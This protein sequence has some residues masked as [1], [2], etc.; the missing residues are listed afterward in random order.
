MGSTVFE[1]L[2]S[3]LGDSNPDTRGAA[4][5]AL[6]KASE[7]G[8]P[9]AVRLV[10]PMLADVYPSVR[11]YALAALGLLSSS[12]YRQVIKAIT[13]RLEDSD[14]SVRRL[15]AEVL[16]NFKEACPNSKSGSFISRVPR[17]P[18]WLSR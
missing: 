6:S 17:T 15:A 9:S 12:D 3:R 1:I 8:N 13:S 18:T 4:L 2:S 7:R 11:R 14:P 10:T 16:D 5:Q